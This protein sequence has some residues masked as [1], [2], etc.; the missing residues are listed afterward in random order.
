MLLKISDSRDHKNYIAK[1]KEIN[2]Q[3]E[4]NAVY[5]IKLW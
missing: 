2:L 1:K 3:V 4:C 5:L